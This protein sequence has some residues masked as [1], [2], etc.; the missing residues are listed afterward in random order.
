MAVYKAFWIEDRIM[1]LKYLGTGGARSCPFDA[2]HRITTVRPSRLANAFGLKRKNPACVCVVLHSAQHSYCSLHMT[3][4]Y[5][6]LSPFKSSRP[7]S[8][9][10]QEPRLVCTSSTRTVATTISPIL[11]YADRDW[12]RDCRRRVLPL[13]RLWTQR[14]Y[15][16]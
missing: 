9:F 4:S 1:S 14:L 12:T 5:K 13:W 11:L 10:T 3:W 16:Q 6:Y 8:Q 7:D 2:R 15:K